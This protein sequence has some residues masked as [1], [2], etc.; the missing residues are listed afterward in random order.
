MN[1][2]YLDNDPETCA[3]LHNNKHVVKMIIE[4][5]QLMSTAH[6]V[7]DGTQTVETTD[8]GRKIKRWK[9]PNEYFDAGLMKAT[10][11]GHPSAIWVRQ[12]KENYIWLN[13]MWQYLL[14]EY[15]YRYGKVHSCEKYKQCL[16][17]WPENIPIDVGFTEPT[18][19][20]PDI[21]KVSGDSLQSYINYYNG[22]KRH[23]ASWKKREIPD[24]YVNC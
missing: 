4:Y 19:A 7:L 10:H 11:T 14:L 8:K 17:P 3:R 12:S 23:I 24:W 2:F 21:Y 9:H 13:K 6:R 22:A 16:Y 5:A 15:T 1:I 18:P 20:M